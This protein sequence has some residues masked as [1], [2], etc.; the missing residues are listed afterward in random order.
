MFPT[1]CKVYKYIQRGIFFQVHYVSIAACDVRCFETSYS[2]RFRSKRKK[3]RVEIKPF[4][5]GSLVVDE[6]LLGDDHTRLSPDASAE[7]LKTAVRIRNVPELYIKESIKE[8][9]QRQL[10]GKG[11]TI[12]SQKAGN[13]LMPYN[14]YYNSHPDLIIS[15]PSGD[16]LR[17][18]AVR[19]EYYSDSQDDS[20]DDSEED[21]F[22]DIN[23]V[24]E[25][26][27]KSGGQAQ[28]YAEA[29]NVATTSVAGQVQDKAL[30]NINKVC[31][32][33]ILLTNE[34][35]SG[36]LSRMIIDFSKAECV[37]EEDKQIKESHQ[38]F[39]IALNQ[40]DIN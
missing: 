33:C 17:L 16:D 29:F 6:N 5:Y 14:I 7:L 31:V 8:Q 4:C 25:L 35:R 21:E 10:D 23:F 2:T 19:A 13:A 1:K 39:D 34:C 30:S 18:I 22:D 20:E 3:Q 27:K 38:C 9:L 24:S 26:E 12:E 11:Y 15:K 37:I 40:S 32:Y 28:L 36:L